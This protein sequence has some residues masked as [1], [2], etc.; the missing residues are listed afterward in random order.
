MTRMQAAWIGWYKATGDAF[1]AMA[2]RLILEAEMTAALHARAESW[3]YYELAA[4]VRGLD[5]TVKA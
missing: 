3:R 2:D 4:L 5:S 1:D